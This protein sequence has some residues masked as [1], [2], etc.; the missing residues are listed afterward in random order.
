MAYT[1]SNVQ[2][3]VQS[4]KTQKLVLLQIAYLIYINHHDVFV[5]DQLFF[6]SMHLTQFT[7]SK[8]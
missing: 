5:N 6:F 3:Y 1:A 2:K 4:K 7:D 8:L